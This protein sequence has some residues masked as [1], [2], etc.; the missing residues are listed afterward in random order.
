MK[1]LLVKMSSMGDILHA[2]PAVTDAYENVPDIRFDWVVE[3]DFAEIPA[4]HVAVDQVIPVALRRWRRQPLR[5]LVG[6]EW[7]A[8][9]TRLRTTPYHAVIDAQGLIKS[10]LICCLVKAPRFGMDR[11]SA[12]EQ[13]AALAYDH[14]F[15]VA[16]DLHAVERLRALFALSLSY[17]VPISRGNY[18]IK[19]L[20]QAASAPG[21]VFCHGSARK[22]K[23]WPEENWI[24][25]ARLTAVSGLGVYLPW[26]TDE[27]HAR[28]QRIAAQTSNAMVLARQSLSELAALFSGA[29]GV[30]AVDTGLGHLAAAL[31]VPTVSLYGP[32]NTRLIGAYGERQVHLEASLSDTAAC[33][34]AEALMNGITPQSAWQQLQAIMRAA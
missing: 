2:L 11:Q 25:L 16:K 28:A 23:L 7:R 12:R 13:M 33:G 5:N 4:W 26:G 22:E 31:N 8:F 19:P 21:L 6:S 15:P 14:A 18:A 30:V 29:I 32:T 24:E 1:V 34:A 10:A 27:E 9:R 20:T 17:S 3:E